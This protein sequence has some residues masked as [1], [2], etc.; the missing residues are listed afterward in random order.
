[1]SS[2]LALPVAPVS[3]KRFWE[4]PFDYFTVASWDALGK[5]RLPVFFQKEEENPSGEQRNEG[6]MAALSNRA[7][8][9]FTHSCVEAG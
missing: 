2:I 7:A 6:G 3:C 5:V 8:Q 4:K 1:M 9:G